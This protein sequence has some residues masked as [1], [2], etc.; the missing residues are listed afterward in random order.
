MLPN[1]GPCSQPLL[2][3]VMAFKS[4]INIDIR[5]S[6]NSLWALVYLEKSQRINREL[7]EEASL[8]GLF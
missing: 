1:I 5:E 4:I 3:V 7:R 2:E 6:H 8:R